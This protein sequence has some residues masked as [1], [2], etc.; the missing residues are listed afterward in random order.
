[1]I[2]VSISQELK[3]ANP[4]MALG[5]MECRVQNTAFSDDLWREIAALTAEIRSN[6]TFDSIK[7]QPQIAATRRMYTVCGKDPSRYRPSA[8]ALMRRIVKGNDLY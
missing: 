5:V 6:L 1:M 3:T 2:K 4:G 8:E 7:E